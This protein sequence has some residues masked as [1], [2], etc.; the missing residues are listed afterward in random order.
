MRLVQSGEEPSY[1]SARGPDDS[2][3]RPTTS[4]KDGSGNSLKVTDSDALISTVEDGVSQDSRNL[5]YAI[6]ASI[7][8]HIAILGWLSASVNLQ[9]RQAL[10]KPGEEITNVRLIEQPMTERLDEPVPKHASAISDRNHSTPIEKIPKVLPA[11]KAPIGHMDMQ[12][13]KLAAMI[14]PAAPNLTLPLND[15]SKKE[16]NKSKELDSQK[17]TAPPRLARD[18]PPRPQRPQVPQKSMEPDL[19]PTRREREIAT[20]ISPYSGSSDFFPEGDA[21]EAVVDINTREEK[22]FSYLLYLKNKIQ[23]VWV[24]PSSA[25]SAGIGG[26]LTVEF[27]IARSGELVSVNLID[28]SGHAIL[29]ESAVR[30]ITV[31]APYYPFPSRMRAKRL[32][33]RANFVYI[34]GNYFR[35]IL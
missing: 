32:R 34:T 19:N 2:P 25:A 28:S 11:P 4:I 35:R 26:S 23:G 17:N 7:A 20:G 18:Y 15:K 6:A 31:A 5:R 24:Y 10:V 12:Q 29:D 9:P 14:P 33:I 30:A 13:Q 8:L 22:F 27:S 21:D 1:R 3:I 16:T